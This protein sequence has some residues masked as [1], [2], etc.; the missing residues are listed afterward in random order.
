MSDEPIRIKRYPNRRFYA[1]HTSRYIS[2]PEIE[3]LIREGASVEILDSQT[4]EDITRSVLM[5]MIAERHP[6]KIAMFP[7]PMLHSML[8]ANK[9][10]TNFYEEYFRNA[11]AYLEYI[12]KQGATDSLPQPMHWMGQWLEQWPKPRDAKRAPKSVEQPSVDGDAE[13][14]ERIARLEEKIAQL[15]VKRGKKR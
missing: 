4:G 5:Q 14:A 6:D 1:S 3:Q 11:L 13:L 7:T 8:R 2:L 10:M 12:Q 15:E 9:L